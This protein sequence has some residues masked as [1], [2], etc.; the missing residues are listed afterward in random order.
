MLCGNVALFV[1]VYEVTCMQQSL[2]TIN[3]TTLAFF[4]KK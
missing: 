3:G 4:G 1:L 2:E